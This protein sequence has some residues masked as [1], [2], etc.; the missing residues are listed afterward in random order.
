MLFQKGN[1]RDSLHVTAD[2][3]T[4]LQSYPVLHLYVLD[5][6]LL[7]KGWIGKRGDDSHLELRKSWCLNFKLYYQISYIAELQ[8]Y[9]WI[10]AEIFVNMWTK[11]P[12]ITYIGEN[13]N[14]ICKCVTIT[15]SLFC[16]YKLN[17]LN[18]IAFT[19][20]LFNKLLC[21][22]V[23]TYVHIFVWNEKNFLF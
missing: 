2:L 11:F 22:D 23:I 21:V 15:R 4:L 3:V 16:L 5:L 14:N 6:N 13:F 17:P 19:I 10:Y 9:L 12:I 7:S 8:K 1:F 18:V 20:D